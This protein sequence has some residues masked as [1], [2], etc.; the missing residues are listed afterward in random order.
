[1]DTLTGRIGL[2]VL[3][4]CVLVLVCATQPINVV[5]RNLRLAKGRVAECAPARD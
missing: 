1:M 5:R 4:L 3:A 2:L